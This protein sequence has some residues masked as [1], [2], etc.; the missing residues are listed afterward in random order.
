M[1][2]F[3]YIDGLNFYE[4]SKG[5]WW[6]PYGWCDWNKTIQNYST[7]AKVT[8]KYFTTEV[9]PANRS[10][11]ERQR[12]HLRA[13]EKVAG[14]EI[15]KG[16][17]RQRNVVCGRCDEL[18]TCPRCNRDSK[19]TEKQT[20]VNIAVHLVEDAIDGRFEEAYLV[21]SDLDLIP[22]VRVALKRNAGARIGILFPPE[23]LISPEFNEI[24]REFPGQLRCR[25]LDLRRMQRFPEDL[26]TRWGLVLPKH[27][28]LGAGPRPK[29]VEDQKLAHTFKKGSHWWEE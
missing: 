24:E 5:K 25:P 7:G 19:L 15:I 13:M 28:R 20:D 14:A 4:R 11:A 2:T 17:L 9:S 29:V 10:A 8:V 12:L 27:W 3:A 23:G 26:P 1:T 16:Q 22:A 21:T 18:M 6:Y